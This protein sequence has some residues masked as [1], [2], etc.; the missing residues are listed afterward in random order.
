MKPMYI[1]KKGRRVSFTVDGYPD[2]TFSGVVTQVRQK[3][4]T[5][6]NR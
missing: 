1:D 4:T 3:A 2:N 6:N 5:S